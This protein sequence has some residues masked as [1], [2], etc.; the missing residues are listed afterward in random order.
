MSRDPSPVAV[1]LAARRLDD[2]LVACAQAVEQPPTRRALMNPW[3]IVGAV[4]AFV[5]L[6][7]RFK[8]PVLKAALPLAL[9]LLKS[10]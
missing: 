5:F 4:A 7:R 2:R 9:G 1:Q 3:V 10:R 6:P 8:K